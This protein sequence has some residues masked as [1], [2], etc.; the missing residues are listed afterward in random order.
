MNRGVR[1][2][3]TADALEARRDDLRK[4]DPAIANDAEAVADVGELAPLLDKLRTAKRDRER[5]LQAIAAMERVDGS[6]DA[7]ATEREIRRHI[8]RWRQLLTA[9]EHVQDTRAALRE[10]L[11]GPIRFT[12]DGRTYRFEGEVW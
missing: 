2:A 4:V 3:D 12:P 5:I 7:T 10:M 6:F 9:R 8:S 11:A 1:R